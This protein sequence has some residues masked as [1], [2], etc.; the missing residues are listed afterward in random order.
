MSTQTARSFARITDKVVVTFVL[1]LSFVVA[2]GTAVL[3]A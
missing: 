3:G 1:F 2:G